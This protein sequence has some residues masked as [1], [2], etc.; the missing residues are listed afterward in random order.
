VVL[1][2]KFKQ[3][4]YLEFEFA[5]N[6]SSQQINTQI[7]HSTRFTAPFNVHLNTNSLSAA[8][9]QPIMQQ[10]ARL[11]PICA[12]EIDVVNVGSARC[13]PAAACPYEA[14]S[15]VECPYCHLKLSKSNNRHFITTPM[16][17]PSDQKNASGIIPPR[18]VGETWSEF[19]SSAFNDGRPTWQWQS[20]WQPASTQSTALASSSVTCSTCQAVFLTTEDF[21]THIYTTQHGDWTVN[22]ILQ[23]WSVLFL[24]ELPC[25]CVFVHEW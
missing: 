7:R 24:L 12:A 13:H 3:I 10:S 25:G 19:E 18:C 23:H 5:W 9:T 16:T 4:S 1:V 11:C 17:D 8:L 14:V 20:Q 21:V 15:V 22:E 6:L 2:R